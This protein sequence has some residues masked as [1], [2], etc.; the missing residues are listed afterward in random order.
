M[1]ELGPTRATGTHGWSGQVQHRP[2]ARGGGQGGEAAAM[3]AHHPL[4]PDMV[5]PPSLSHSRRRFATM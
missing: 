3:R 5:P 2:G 4:P 1:A